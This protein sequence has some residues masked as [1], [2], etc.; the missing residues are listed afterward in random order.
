MTPLGSPPW[1]TRGSRSCSASTTTTLPGGQR[2]ARARRVARRPR[3]R[4][5]L[6]RQGRLAHVPRRRRAGLS[7]STRTAASRPSPSCGA[8]SSITRTRS[9]RPRA[10]AAAT[11]SG[12]PPASG[13]V[14]AEMFP[15]LDAG[16]SRT[17]VELF[18]IWLN[19]PRADKMV[20]AALLDALERRRSRAHASRD[21]AGRDDRGH[22]RRRRATR[23]A[24]ALPPPPNSWAAGPSATSRSGRSSWRPARAGRC[25]R[26]ARQRTA[27]S[28]SSAATALG[29]AGARASPAQTA[30]IELRADVDAELEN[31]RRRG[32]APAAA[33]PPDRRAG[34]AARP[35]RDEHAA[36]RSS[37]RS[38][39]T[40]ARSS[41]AGPGT[42]GSGARREEKRF[43]RHAD[44]KTETPAYAGA[45][46]LENG[47]PSGGL[48]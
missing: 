6:R 40:S 25:R 14:H 37:R 9:A 19:L 28:T 44:G 47:P 45:H 20:A 27:R 33:G 35:V 8:A 7:R 26:R 38:P 11:C 48:R 10:T 24:R 18:Q 3:H 31:G 17:R 22:R 32:R 41:A 21:A 36:R 23:R 39:T 5:G 30:G 12:S 34:R 42:A 46:P 13:I 29:V 15:L 43:A 1:Q 16:R 4:A 2:A